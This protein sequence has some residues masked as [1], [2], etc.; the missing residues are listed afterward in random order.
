MVTA[1]VAALNTVRYSGYRRLTWNVHCVQ[2]A[3]T[4]TS[5]A[6]A[7]PSSTSDMSSAACDTDSVE[8]LAREIGRLTFHTEVR[9]AETSSAA[10]SHGR[11]WVSGKNATNTPAPTAMTTATKNCAAGG[12]VRHDR[13]SGRDVAL[14]AAL[15]LTT[16]FSPNSAVASRACIA[17]LMRPDHRLAARISAAGSPH[18]TIS[19]ST[20]RAPDDPISIS[21]GR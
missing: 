8:P 11:G 20:A 19:I 9:Q 15:G 13:S 7:G 16:G 1:C 21:T 3:A 18:H 12:S 14:T 4:A 2:A 5:M 10:Y 17:L 6:C